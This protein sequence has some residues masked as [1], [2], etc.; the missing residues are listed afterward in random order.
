MRTNTHHT[1][2]VPTSA[3]GFTLLEI[4]V[5]IGA[6][7]LIGVML[8]QIFS[9]AGES[10]R[11]GRQ[12]SRL[13]QYVT[14]LETQLRD[15]FQR[16]SRDG[17]LVIRNERTTT[18]VHLD[19]DSESAGLPPRQRRVDEILFFAQGE[20]QSAREALLPGRTAT[21]TAARIYIGHGL[22]WDDL[23]AA[24]DDP[25]SIDDAN[26]SRALAPY[27]GQPG[28]SQ[29]ARD[30]IL[31]RHA[32]LLSPPAR[33]EPTDNRIQIGLQPAAQSVFSPLA[34]V[35]QEPTLP[36]A[37]AL[38]RGDNS[39]PNFASGVVDVASH[40]LGYVRDVLNSSPDF[41]GNLQE[42]EQDQDKFN[43]D[44]ET[45]TQALDRQHVAMLSAFPAISSELLTNNRS[46]M[47]CEPA[48][49]NVFGTLWNPTGGWNEPYQRVDQL[50]LSGSNL[51]PRCTEFIVEWSFGAIDK[52]SG[53]VV[54]HGLQ[55]LGD[56]VEFAR[57]Y[58]SNW[59]TEGLRITGL[60][61]NNNGFHD[62]REELIHEPSSVTAGSNYLTSFFG[63]YDPTYDWQSN[64]LD[65][66]LLWVW[67]TMIRITLR[68][69]DPEN[70]GQEQTFQMVFDVP[71]QR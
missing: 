33:S 36:S 38:V 62:I 37:G 58:N 19:P 53:Q 50:A 39:L 40:G 61:P 20:Y 44:F 7:A 64:N 3:R 9:T 54:W 13:T 66:P 52:S 1:S 35:R 14:L 57:P 43:P 60:P 30:W 32:T 24:Y 5:S 16:M 2:V 21:A 67:P 48:P 63:I 22:P 4:L 51:V 69:A 42:W 17:F 71:Q 68:L 41:T 15:D 27:F 29:Y 47:R 59:P 34:A 70:P 46:R 49:P 11:T 25:V 8:F 23:R 6:L 45:G 26:Q 56:G 55:R 65:E 12:T 28:P 18:D 31:M 10:V